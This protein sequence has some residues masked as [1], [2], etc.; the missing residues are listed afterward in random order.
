MEQNFLKHCFF[1]VLFTAV[2]WAAVFGTVIVLF[3]FIND[4]LNLM[5]LLLPLLLYPPYN[6][7]FISTRFLVLSL[8]G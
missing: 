7:S 4:V 3:D 8:D 5:L 1:L 6:S 2:P